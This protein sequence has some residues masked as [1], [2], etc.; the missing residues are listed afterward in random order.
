MMLIWMNVKKVGLVQRKMGMIKR[1]Q[2]V[3]GN[4]GESEDKAEQ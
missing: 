2:I 4:E 1:K 3:A